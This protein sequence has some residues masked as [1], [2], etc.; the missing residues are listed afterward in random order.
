M[1]WD[2]L[3]AL[4]TILLVIVGI[5][6]AIYAALQLADFRR[7]SRIKHIIDLVNQ[8]ET[9]PLAKYRRDLAQ[10][11][12]SPEGTLKP[13][14][15]EN[16]PPELWDIMNFFEHM[17]YLLDGKYL[18]VDEVAVEFHYWIL[19]V[20][21]DSSELVKLEQAEDSLYYEYFEKMARRLQEYDRPRTGRLV[22]PSKSD[23]ED[24]YSD[25]ARLVVG[26]PMPRKRRRK[27]RRRQGFLN[28]STSPTP[29]GI[30]GDTP[31]AL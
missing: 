21:A 15:L 1:G 28:Q 25:E 12:L 2:A 6:T 16:P 8:F 9:D 24:F 11:R 4:G 14:D 3:T 29:Q 10:K 13:L 30:A 18:N 26:S 27:R 17:G 20:W 19:R 7:E 23:I 31:T 22:S 5:A